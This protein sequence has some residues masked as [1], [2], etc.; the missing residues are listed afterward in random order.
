MGGID[1]G[2]VEIAG[3]PMISYVLEALRSQVEHVVINA[4][5]NLDRYATLD[6]KVVSDRIADYQGPLAGM[7][8]ALAAS[9]TPLIMT[10]PCDAPL[11]PTDLLQRQLAALTESAAEIAVVSVD[12]QLQ[13]VFLLMQRSVLPGLEE[14]LAAG[15]RKIDRWIPAHRW[16]SVD[17]SDCRDCF[18]NVNSPEDAAAVASR[19]SAR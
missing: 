13:P 15:E 16:I 8:S 1:K 10:V 9:T 7:A 2:L 17:L 5:R 11:L 12:A 18:I 19:L 14:C 6:A 4:N 3:R